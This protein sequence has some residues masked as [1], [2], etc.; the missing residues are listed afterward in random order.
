LPA[1][2]LRASA[3]PRS[4]SVLQEGAIDDD[5]IPTHLPPDEMTKAIEAAPEAYFPV[6]GEFISRFADLDLCLF[7]LFKLLLQRD[8]RV[9]AVLFYRNNE[10]GGRL[11]IANALACECLPEDRLVGQWAKLRERM[12]RHSEVR[13]FVAHHPFSVH[14]Y[15]AMVIQSDDNDATPQPVSKTFM[16]AASVGPEG[17][18]NPK[19]QVWADT[20]SGDPHTPLRR[21]GVKRLKSEMTKLVATKADL[22]TFIEYLEANSASL[23]SRVPPDVCAMRNASTPKTSHK[24]K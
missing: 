8:E 12:K 11:S 19:K 7:R 5:V 23:N 20:V 15:I 13:N 21:V 14:H 4:F 6:L 3:R 1:D 16:G 9:A 17:R 18:I 10:F 24:Y 2:P 22:L